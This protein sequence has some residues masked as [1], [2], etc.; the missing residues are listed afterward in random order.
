MAHSEG[1]DASHIPLT[2]VAARTS[3]DE[4]DNELAETSGLLGNENR[5][6]QKSTISHRSQVSQAY[7]TKKNGLAEKRRPLQL[8]QDLLLGH[9][10]SVSL[11]IFILLGAIIGIAIAGGV[12]IYKTSLL[13]W[14]ISPMVSHSARR[15]GNHVD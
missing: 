14:R 10:G 3:L 8:A 6:E 13:R 1:P 2:A 7:A 4:L 11:A 5:H 9:G 12:W 15:R